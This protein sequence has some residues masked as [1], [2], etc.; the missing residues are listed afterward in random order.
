M[1][2]VSL[3]NLDPPM[4][5]APFPAGFPLTRESPRILGEG[6]LTDRAVSQQIRKELAEQEPRYET[7]APPYPSGFPRE[8]V[9]TVTPRTPGSRGLSRIERKYLY[10]KNDPDIEIAPSGFPQ[11]PRRMVESYA[12]VSSESSRDYLAAYAEKEVRERLQR[13]TPPA[14]RYI[15]AAPSEPAEST[16]VV[17]K[18]WE[19]TQEAIREAET[20]GKIVQAKL[21][22]AAHKAS[23]SNQL[24]QESDEARRLEVEARNEARDTP[25]KARTAVIRIK[26]ELADAKG[27]VAEQDLKKAEFERESKLQ[28]AKVVTRAARVKR[29]E[30]T[31]LER[32]LTR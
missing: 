17:Q 11:T 28:E 15:I 10:E 23:R 22:E 13:A 3:R 12:P 25:G 8:G 20:L 26:E 5:H 14:E 27:E 9:V 7:G 4:H 18:W 30:L 19:K 16:H 2:T 24:K 31:E 1:A 29:A 6:A 21:E 32:L